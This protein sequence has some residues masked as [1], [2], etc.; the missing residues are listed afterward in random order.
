[1]LVFKQKNKY[2][3]GCFKCPREAHKCRICEGLLLLSELFPETLAGNW[4][5]NVQFSPDTS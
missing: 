5:I 4:K 3:F 1:M 2:V